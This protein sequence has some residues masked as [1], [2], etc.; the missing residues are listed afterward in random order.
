MEY[1]LQC[2]CGEKVT[3]RESAAGLTEQCHCGRTLVIPS[4]R[5]LRRGAGLSEPRLPPEKV[6]E[7]LLLAGRLPEERHCILCNDAT[8]GSVLC[9]AD[10]ERAYVRSGHPPLWLYLLSFFTLGWLGVALARATAKEDREWGKDCVFDLPLRV[11]P[12]CQPRLSDPEELKAALRSVPAYG[13]LLEKYPDARV[14]L[15]GQ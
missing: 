11:C 1:L 9:T 12:T 13:P 5:E 7:V 6:V 8:D 15:A 10:C 4:L 2:E 3:V 14:S